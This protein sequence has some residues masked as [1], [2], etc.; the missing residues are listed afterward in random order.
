MFTKNAVLADN[1]V[2]GSATTF[3]WYDIGQN[4]ANTNTTKV[5]AEMPQFVNTTDPYS[6]NFY[7]LKVPQEPWVIDAWVGD[8]PTFPEFPRYI[9]AVAPQPGGFAV[10]IR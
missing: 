4:L 2:T 10:R 3:D 7:R 9:G 5:L 1:F 6:E 8:D